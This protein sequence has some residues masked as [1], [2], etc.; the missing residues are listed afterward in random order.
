MG[1]VGER[2]ACAAAVMAFFATIFLLNAL[3]GPPDFLPMF[4]ALG[5]TYLA[6]FVGIVAGY[7]WARWFTMGVAF[8][9]LVIGV[10]LWTQIG[11]DTIVIVFGGSHGLA[12][13]ALAG[14]GPREAFD[15][16]ADWRTRWRL[17][18]NAAN[19]LGKAIM[20]TGASLPYL[21]MA[22]LAPRQGAL[23]G[24]LLLVGA[25]VLGA[26]GLRALVKM[27]TWGVL[28]LAG[29]A[30]LVAGGGTVG[31]ATAP[32]AFELWPVAIVLAG[33]LLAAAVAPFAAPLWRAVRK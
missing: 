26:G 17:D 25:L 12:A 16:R 32:S 15:G 5:L 2:K 18:D 6:G 9:G 11:L 8:S 23:V 1:F 4:L 27:K 21:I 28:A 10:L 14:R 13:L 29:A 31:M 7:F 33:A 3:A 24:T 30:V 22:G 20:R 19:R